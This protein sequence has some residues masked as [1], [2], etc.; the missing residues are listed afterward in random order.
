MV[1]AL[2]KS[3]PN[4]RMHRC[5]HCDNYTVGLSVNTVKPCGKCGASPPRTPVS[6]ASSPVAGQGREFV[7]TPPTD[8]AR[9]GHRGVTRAWEEA[10]RASVQ[11]NEAL[12]G[13]LS[14]YIA[15]H[16]HF[17]SD[18]AEHHCLTARYARESVRFALSCGGAPNPVEPIDLDWSHLSVDEARHELQELG[19]AADKQQSHLWE[20][21]ERAHRLREEHKALYC[22]FCTTEL[23]TA[24]GA[25]PCCD[26]M[27]ATRA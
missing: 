8:T 25:A 21:E 19:A 14:G 1:A 13:Y 11:A 3:I 18:Q 4:L 10:Q 15:F 22:A 23:T 5:P 24:P 6:G 27:A 7:K 17:S 2:Q 9:A 16:S 26:T 12:M 20:A